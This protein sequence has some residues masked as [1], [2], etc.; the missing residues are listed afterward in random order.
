MSSRCI[1]ASLIH[2]LTSATATSLVVTTRGRGQSFTTV[3]ERH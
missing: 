3:A 2:S 1:T